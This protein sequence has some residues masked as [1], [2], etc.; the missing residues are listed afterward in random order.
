MSSKKK[1][2]ILDVGLDL[3]IRKGY[4]HLGIQEILDEAN[5]PKGSFYYYFKNKEDFG[6]QAIEHY[7]L[8][9]EE[10]LDQYLNLTE[11]NPKLRLMNF[12][13]KMKKLYSDENFRIGSLFGN[14][15]QEMSGL[16]DSYSAALEYRFKYLEKRFY[17]VIL[18]GQETGD[19]NKVL[20]AHHIASFMVNAWEGALLRMK[21]GRNDDA[22][23]LLIEYIKYYL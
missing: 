21:S 8:R 1:N 17:D 23:N 22:I 11:H 19:I 18:E 10:L 5:I 16:N 7:H 15:S 12:F 20:P 6:L 2:H 13:N 9:I 4:H 3:I 14:F